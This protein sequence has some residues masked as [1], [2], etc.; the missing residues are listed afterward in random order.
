MKAA[1]ARRLIESLGG[2]WA[3]FKEWLDGDEAA[4]AADDEVDFYT[5]D[6]ARFMDEAQLGGSPRRRASAA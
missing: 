6:I 2:R 4:V 1:E 3:D 5:A